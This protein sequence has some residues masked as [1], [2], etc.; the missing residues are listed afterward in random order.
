MYQSAFMVMPGVAA[1]LD[2]NDPNFKVLGCT[3]EFARIGNKPADQIIGR[4]LLELFPD[5]PEFHGRPRLALFRSLRKVIESGQQDELPVQRYDLEDSS[6]QFREK[7]W[8]ILNRPFFADGKLAGI[9]HAAEDITLEILDERREKRIRGF[10]QAFE[11]FMDA[12]QA[13]CIISGPDLTIDL[14]NKS[15]LKYLCSDDRIIG[16]PMLEALPDP[17]I[18]KL[19]T[20]FRKVMEDEEPFEDRQIPIELDCN[21]E[22]HLHYFHIRF[23]PFYENGNP[24]ASGVLAYG[25]DVTDKVLALEKLREKHQRYRTLIEEAPIATALYHGPDLMIQYI[26]DIMLSYW[27]KDASV[28]GKTIADALPEI[29]GQPFI[30]QM[31]E[32][33]RSGKDFVGIGQVAELMHGGELRKAYFNYTY[34]PLRDQH[35]EVYGIH[36]TAI[37]VSK[38]VISQQELEASELKFRKL[39]ET[40]E[41]KVAERTFLI[42]QLNET[43]R[44]AE[45]TGKFGSYR[46][47]IG[48]GELSYSD[49]LFRVLGAEVDG[50]EPS[51]EKFME[52]VHPDDREFVRN[53]AREH[54]LRGEPWEHDYRIVRPNGEI[55]WTRGSTALIKASDGQDY[56]IGTLQDITQEKT[57]ERQ[58]VES[59]NK[60]ID[61]NRELESFAYISSH[62]LQEPLRKIQTF[63]SRIIEEE[64][65]K[66][67]SRAEN[68][69]ERMMN[70]AH[71]M[72]IL[73]DDLLAYSRSNIEARNFERV[74]LSELLAEISEEVSEDLAVYEAMIE[75]DKLGYVTIIPF[76]FRQLLHNLIS[77]ALKFSRPEKRPHIYITSKSDTGANF[78][79]EQLDPAKRYT[80]I[81]FADNGIGFP[82]E[83]ASKIFEVFQRLH[84]REKYSGTGIGLAIVRKIVENHEGFVSATGEPNK[85]ATFDIYIPD[86]KI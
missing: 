30:G 3:Q 19:S 83:F 60:L 22:K 34:K 59:N 63:A 67:G 12:P 85:G 54:F 33:Y 48:T 10:R 38:Q 82:P 84:T 5:N 46:Y 9:M 64:Q 55:I 14:A 27:G 37:D 1:L 21:N 71:R 13:I 35:G 70:A 50:F 40:L 68:Y 36:H 20:I 80:H 86:R 24:A 53:D 29:A 28:K 42:S 51:L 44:H 17:R 25:H 58:L 78:K 49:N 6:G 31:K 61:M 72:Q 39:S 45:R 76:Q 81:R 18:I 62:D 66:L 43:F 79:I 56:L 73:I 11:L 2:A 47:S 8:R 75:T 74:H 69:F 15:L 52:F 65:D 32:A 23:Q 57:R 4:P 26:N 77:N 16:K 7:Y 41:E